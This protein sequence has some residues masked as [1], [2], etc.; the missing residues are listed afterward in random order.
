MSS[1]EGFGLRLDGHSTFIIR[2]EIMI[3]PHINTV[4]FVWN[5][6]RYTIHADCFLKL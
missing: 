1:E 3:L 2:Q 5:G 4:M 6:A